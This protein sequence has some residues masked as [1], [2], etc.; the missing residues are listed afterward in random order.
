MKYICTKDLYLNRYDEE[1]FYIENKYAHIPKDSIWE[2]DEETIK[3]IG[4]K[5][6]V[7]LDRVWKSKKT[8]TH[9]WLEIDKTTLLTYFKPLDGGK[10]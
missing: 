9:Q 8:K 10:E 7:H 1:G 5:D 6:S 4:G 2:E 3:F